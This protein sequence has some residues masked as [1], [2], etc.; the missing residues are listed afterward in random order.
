MAGQRYIS[1][2]TVTV[3]G[4]SDELAAECAIVDF[5]T[6]AA[7]EPDADFRTLRCTF[8]LHQRS[9]SVGTPGINSNLTLRMY[10]FP[11]TFAM[12]IQKFLERRVCPPKGEV[13]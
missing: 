10:P 8:A 9:V 12:P 2:G 13:D 6:A 4:E 5:H 11:L 1:K 3:A 7:V